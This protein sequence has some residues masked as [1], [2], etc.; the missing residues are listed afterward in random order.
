[1]IAGP[2]ASGKSGA[3]IEIA[4][5]K[6]GVVINCDSMQIYEILSI[7][8]ARP[9]PQDLE[10]AEH[11]LFGYVNPSQ[12]YSVARWLSDIDAVIGEVRNRGKTPIIVGGTGLYLKSL[13]E[14]LS[15]I[16][17][18]DPDIRSALRV[19]AQSSSSSLYEELQSL[20]PLSA[21]SLEPG[22]SQRIVR[23]LE[24]IKS[25]GKPL[26]WWQTRQKSEPILPADQCE[27]YLLMPDR[28]QLHAR[29]GSRFH[30]MIEMGALEEVKALLALGLSSDK[31]AMRAIGVEHLAKAIGG[32]DLLDEAIEKSIISTRQ[33]AKRQCTFFKHQFTAEF[34]QIES[35]KTLKKLTF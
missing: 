19:A 1:M 4:N 27:R 11:R 12:S 15:A 28:A 21:E 18:I 8:T 31:P 34:C 20:D 17:E 26:G 33:Y 10:R 2:T 7:L 23:A 32:L 24:V 35:F 29:I 6:N 22:D 14:G 25:T 9:D 30:Q 16:P 5:R 3:A 13:M